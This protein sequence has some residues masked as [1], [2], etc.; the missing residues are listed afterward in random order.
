MVAKEAGFREGYRHVVHE[1]LLNIKR[2][3][4]R[5]RN[6]S[7]DSNFYATCD[8]IEDLADQAIGYMEEKSSG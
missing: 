1:L 3:C 5:G 7:G 4:I 8:H 6:S 2:S